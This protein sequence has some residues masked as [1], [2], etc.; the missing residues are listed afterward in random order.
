M[1][2]L[3]HTT[4]TIEMMI[5]EQEINKTLDQL[6]ER[7]NAHYADSERLLMVGLLKG[8]V[9]FMADLCRRIKGHVEIDFMSV[10][11]YGNTMNS[12]RDVKVLKDVQSDI[13]GRDVLIVEDLIDSG[14]TLNKVREMLLLREPKSLALCT[15]LDKPERREVD[16]YVDFIGITIPDEFIVGYGIDYAE[17]YRNLPYIAKVVPLD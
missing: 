14:N 5:S 13:A 2:I 11:S 3:S 12:S 6:A 7:I 1:D 4:S 15:L 17:Q 9:V 16:V 10:S 8:S